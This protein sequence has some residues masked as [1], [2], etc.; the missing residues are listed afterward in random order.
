LW[1]ANKKSLKSDFLEV[2]DDILPLFEPTPLQRRIID[3][4]VKIQQMP[5]RH[6][7]IHACGFVSGGA[8]AQR[9]EGTVFRAE[10]WP[11]QHRHRGG[12]AAQGGQVGGNATA[13]WRAK[14]R[15]ALLHISS[16][17]VRMRDATDATTFAEVIREAL[18]TQE[19]IVKLA[20]QGCEILGED[21]AGN[22]TRIIRP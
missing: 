17:A 10:Q 20:M 12:A 16:E 22:R 3:A 1:Y 9:H 15:R 18:E 19:A 11:G 13:V 21:G 14:P 8:A 7:W 4:A 6:G 5:A 2:P